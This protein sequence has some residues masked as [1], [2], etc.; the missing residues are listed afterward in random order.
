VRG[1]EVREVE[2][3]ESFVVVVVVVFV[4]RAVA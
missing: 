3:D 2:R 1:R 4:I